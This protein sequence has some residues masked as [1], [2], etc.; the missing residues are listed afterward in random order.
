MWHEF[1]Y[2]RHWLWK[3]ELIVWAFSWYLLCRTES[4]IITNAHQLMWAK[5]GE[6]IYCKFYICATAYLNL[7]IWTQSNPIICSLQKSAVHLRL[8]WS[9]VPH[10]HFVS[11][12]FILPIIPCLWSHN[13]HSQRPPSINPVMNTDFSCCTVQN[14]PIWHFTRC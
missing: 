8:M 14:A 1:T 10:V 3:D 4:S 9:F 13:W 12:V 6:N 11:S 7:C 5:H 2:Q